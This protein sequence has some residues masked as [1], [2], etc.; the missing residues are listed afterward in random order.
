MTFSVSILTTGSEILD[1]RVLDTNSNYVARE[2]AEHGLSL[3]RVLA[4]D[5]VFDDLVKGLEYLHGYSELVITSGGLGPTADDLTRDMVAAYCSVELQEFPEA[6]EHL[7]QFYAKRKRTL[8]PTN[9]K[10]ALLPVGS[11]MIPNPNGTAPGFISRTK[12]GKIVCSLSGVPREF[13]VMFTETVLPLILSECGGAKRINRRAF[14]LFGLPESVVG[15]R[16]V[17]LE[18]PSSISVSYR[19]AFPEVH[20]VLKSVD[21]G[22]ELDEAA[23]RVLTS[24]MSDFIFSQTG[25]Q[26]FASALQELLVKEKATL[27]VAESCTGGMLGELLSS[28]AGASAFFMG[29]VLAYSNQVKEAQLG[30]SSD[31]IA[32]VGAVSREVAAAM[33]EG[34]RERFGTTY[35]LAT[36][37]IAGPDGGTS[38]KPVGTFFVALASPSQ[39]VVRHCLF[40][41]DRGNIRR[42]AAYTA[43][44]LLRRILKHIPIEETFPVVVR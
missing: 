19:A 16:V 10:Q 18:L 31:V 22:P 7:E 44:E 35:G 32:K 1:G 21:D 8:D 6:R 37:G 34:A 17:D 41:S 33:A 43:G 36:T 5:D 24:T 27:A 28:Q 15:K 38:E 25:E 9:L 13:Q 4:V 20:L 2:L 39:T 42:Y 11:Q 30:V 3:N 14:K 29:G 40:V 12:A 26:K 23:Q